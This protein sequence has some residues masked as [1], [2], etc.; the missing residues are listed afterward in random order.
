[1][2]LADVSEL[3]DSKLQSLGTPLLLVEEQK[4]LSRKNSVASHMSDDG[5]EMIGV[6]EVV[7]PY[8]SRATSKFS[9]FSSIGSPRRDYDPQG[10]QRARSWSPDATKVYKWEPID[11][12]VLKV[13]M[14]LKSAASEAVYTAKS[15]AAAAA[16]TTRER[17]S[18]ASETVMR[19]FCCRITI[20]D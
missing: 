6:K 16:E 5:K 20:E 15:A 19:C 14:D 9:S 3:V 17:A 4:D 1:M 13:L 7:S 2:Q 10:R 11:K 18:S 12:N 8:R